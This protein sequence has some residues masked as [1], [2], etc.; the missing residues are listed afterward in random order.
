MSLYHSRPYAALLPC[1]HQA[2]RTWCTENSRSVRWFGKLLLPEGEKWFLL[3]YRSL[4]LQW[5]FGKFRSLE[6]S[7]YSF[8]NERQFA[9][10]FIFTTKN[11]AKHMAHLFV[12][13]RKTINVLGVLLW[14]IYWVAQ[15]CTS[16]ERKIEKRRYFNWCWLYTCSSF[17]GTLWPQEFNIIQRTCDIPGF[18][19]V[20]VV[21]HNTDNPMVFE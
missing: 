1:F 15:N 9:A 20:F 6:I 12:Y 16:I 5:N 2:R 4:I 7:G 17:I 10:S 18:Y 8:Q 19:T 3:K 21:N 14:L 13:C 11:E